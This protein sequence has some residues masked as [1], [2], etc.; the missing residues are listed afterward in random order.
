MAVTI[1]CFLPGGTA[2]MGRLPVL[3]PGDEY[4]TVMQFDISS[5]KS[6]NKREQSEER[7]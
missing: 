4:A 7:P 5:G 6:L 3:P 2:F 1:A